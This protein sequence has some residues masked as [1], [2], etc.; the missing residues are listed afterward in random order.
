VLKAIRCRSLPL[1][2][3]SAHFAVQVCRSIRTIPRND[4]IGGTQ[5]NGTWAYDG[6]RKL[7]R[8]QVGGDGGNSGISLAATALGCTLYSPAPDVNFDGNNPARLGLGGRPLFASGEAAAF[9]CRSLPTRRSLEAGS[10]GCSTCSARR[11]TAAR[12]PISMC[13]AMSS[14]G[15]HVPCGDWVALADRRSGH[16]G[17]WS[18]Q[19]TGPTSPAPTSLDLACFAEPVDDVVGTRRG[20][21]FV[22]KNAD[23]SDPTACIKR[24]TPR[25][26]P[27]RFIS[28]VAIDPEIQNHA[29]V[30]F[31]G[32]NA[33][34]RPRRVTFSTCGTTRSGTATWTD[35]ISIWATCR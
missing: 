18:G 26:S 27:E 2:R 28:A 20:R 34:P 7:V 8:E 21:L 16:G 32:Y 31:S 15:I 35:L 30:S 12:R 11:M 9:T 10:S 23:A 19:A 3:R 33:T 22:S 25:R 13:I 4:L 1:K 24:S 17:D 14:S 6:P 29:F 5:D